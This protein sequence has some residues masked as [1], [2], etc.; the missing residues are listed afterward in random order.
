MSVSGTGLVPALIS[1]RVMLVRWTGTK[2]RFLGLRQRSLDLSTV[3]TAHEGLSAGERD[4]RKIIILDHHLTRSGRKT[5]QASS[6]R[7]DCQV[8]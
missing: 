6:C 8:G 4:G 3:V 1:C 5:R 2:N 7:Q